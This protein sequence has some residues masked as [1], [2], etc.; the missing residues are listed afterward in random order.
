[1]RSKEGFLKEFHIKMNPTLSSKG[2]I[3]LAGAI[4]GPKDISESVAHAGGAAA[5]APAH[6]VKGYIEKEMLIPKIDYSLCISCGLCK[7]V[8]APAAIDVDQDRVYSVNEV[9]CKS[10]GMCMPACPTGAIQL[11]NFSD[12]QLRDEI[13]PLSGGEAHCHD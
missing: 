9:A 12:D 10:C 5:L 3:Y 4:Q 6:L 1:L 13:I 11:I 8:C 7:T 2:G